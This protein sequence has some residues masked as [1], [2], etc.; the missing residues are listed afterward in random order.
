[1][2]QEAEES[3]RLR[4]ISNVTS[5]LDGVLLRMQRE[6]R[7]RKKEEEERQRR[8]RDRLAQKKLD[9]EEAA[10]KEVERAE[11]LRRMEKEVSRAGAAQGANTGL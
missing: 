7:E 10:A 4:H 8:E 5:P 9:E 6:E 11:Y 1:M 3:A 2:S